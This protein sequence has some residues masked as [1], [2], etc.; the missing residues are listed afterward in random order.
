MCSGVQHSDTVKF[1]R[2][3]WAYASCLANPSP[4][5][6]LP[7]CPAPSGNHRRPSF[8]QDTAIAGL[9]MGGGGGGGGMM[10]CCC[11]VF[12]VEAERNSFLCGSDI[13]LSL[14][15]SLSLSH[16][17]TLSLSHIHS[18]SLS[19]S[20]TH[21]H[22]HTHTLSLSHS[23]YLSPFLLHLP[24]SRHKNRTQAMVM[25]ETKLYNAERAEAEAKDL[26][27][28][29]SKVGR[30]YLHEKVR[31]FDFPQVSGHKTCRE[32]LRSLSVLVFLLGTRLRDMRDKIG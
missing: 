12:L 18:L 31:T 20:L 14:S 26:S 27:H 16:T 10:P 21:T 24:L 25:L 11:C 17:H 23:I 30:L 15:L 4:S 1:D 9:A 2:R 7:S 29:R 32:I 6:P 28:R 8:W 19:L 3:V 13:S 5:V 22:T